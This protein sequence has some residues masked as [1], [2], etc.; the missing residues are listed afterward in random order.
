MK[1]ILT[2]LFLIA[3]LPF[4]FAFEIEMNSDVPQ[5]ETIIVKISGNIIDPLIKDNIEF[6]R[7]HV[8]TFFDY[9]VGKLGNYYYIYFQTFDKPQNNY[10][11]NITG[12]R[13]YSGSQISSETKSNL[14]SINSEQADFY[15]KPG[16][17]ITDGN[18]SATLQNLNSHILQISFQ[19]NFD[20]DSFKFYLNNN[21]IQDDDSFSILPNDDSTINSF[22]KDLNETSI[23][24]ISIS[25]TKTNYEIPIYVILSLQGESPEE[26]PPVEGENETY[27]ENETSSDEGS[28]WDFFKKEKD[29]VENKTES[30]KDEFTDN[31]SLIEEENFL[32]TCEELKGVVCLSDQICQGDNLV[33][34]KDS[35]CCLSSCIEK[36]DKKSNKIIGWSL[37]GLIVLFLIWFRAK[38]NR[39]KKRKN[40]FPKTLNK[41]F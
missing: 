24:T 11:I 31:E 37:V 27:S 12:I 29:V 13:Y 19:S 35:Q 17:V 5:G 20:S 36:E 34:A 2:L 32:K 38:Y 16:F 33:N 39:T 40:V 4:G 18:F 10:S 8:R 26:S 1:G 3:F 14:F 6:Y 15:I 41:K 28:F 22:L 25:S 9:D 30:P 21:Q 23:N 7:G